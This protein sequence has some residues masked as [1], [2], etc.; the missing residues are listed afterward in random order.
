MADVVQTEGDALRWLQTADADAIAS[1]EIGVDRLE[2]LYQ[3]L[4][5]S[6]DRPRQGGPT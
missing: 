5:A 6:G 1:A 4:L 2:D 3:L